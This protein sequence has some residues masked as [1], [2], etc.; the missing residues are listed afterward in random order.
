MLKGHVFDEQ[1]FSNQIFAL[2]I[3]TFLNGRNGVSDNYKNGMNVTY[4]GSTVTIDSGSAIVQGRPVEEDT[5]TSLEAGTDI[6]YCKLVIEIDLDKENTETECNQLAYKIVKSASAYPSLTQTNIVK[7]NSGIYQYELA[8]FKTGAS[9]ITDFQDMRTFLDFDSIYDEIENT[10][11]GIQNNS[12]LVFKSEIIN[13]LTT[14]DTN[15]PL[16]ANQGKVLDE[17]KVDKAGGTLSG[18]FTFNGDVTSNNLKNKNGS[19]VVYKENAFKI[20]DLGSI[21]IPTGSGITLNLDLGSSLQSFVVVSMI[22]NGTYKYIPHTIA[23][24]GVVYINPSDLGSQGSR[25]SLKIVV[26]EGD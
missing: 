1:Y 17:K 18:D 15:K 20:I 2:F 22:V 11:T 25:I 16:S 7:N 10:I 14:T 12:S 23:F 4:N 26:I 19:G 24:P 13:N 3:N 6:A 8:R 5:E 9:G 21:T